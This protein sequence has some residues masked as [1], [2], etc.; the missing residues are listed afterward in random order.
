M[1]IRLSEYPE[2]MAAVP[3]AVRGD[4]SLAR[5]NLET[6][7]AKIEPSCEPGDLAHVIQILADVE[8]QA[9]NTELGLRLQERAVALGGDHPLLPILCAKSLLRSFKRP[10]LALARLSEAESA[11]TSNWNPIPDDMP[12][13]WYERE[14]SSLRHAAQQEAS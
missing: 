14:I 8:A 7:I 2:Y 13:D 11:L 12:R 9:G 3:A 5:S 1:T 4:Y 10:D 6:L